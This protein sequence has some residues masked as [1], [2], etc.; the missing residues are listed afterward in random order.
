M[1]FEWGSVDCFSMSDL[2]RPSYTLGIE[3]GATR[4]SVLFVGPDDEVI[5]QFMAGPANLRLMTKDDL[6]A[7]LYAIRQRLPYLPDAIGIGLAGV[8][9]QQDLDT[10]R[11]KV[12]RIWPGVPCAP[13]D[14]LLTAME[15]EPW[16]EECLAQILV[17]SGTGSCFL[18]RHRNGD[19]V[20]VGGRGHILGDRASACD[21]AQNALREVIAQYDS[22]E[23]WSALGAG[24]LTQL[25]LNEPEALID[26]SLVANKTELASVAKTVFDTAKSDRDPISMQVL[27]EAAEMLADDAIATARRLDL[28]RKEPVQFIFNGGVLLKNDEFREKVERQIVA[29]FPNAVLSPLSRPSTWGAVELGRRLLTEE[30]AGE[31]PQDH[32]SPEGDP[33]T[34]PPVWHPAEASP[35]EQRNPKSEKLSELSLSE[36]IGLFVEEDKKIPDAV[37]AA[38]ES[39]EWTIQEVVKAFEGGGRLIYTGA[40]TSGRLGVLDASECPPT[41][42]VSPLQVQG[43]IAGGQS[44]IWSASEGSEDDSAAGARAVRQRNVCEKDVVIAI[45]ASGHAPFIWGCLAEAKERGAKV[46]LLTC[47]PAYT[48]HPLPDQVIALDTGAEILTGS[49]RLK[50]GTA[51]KMTLNLITTLAMTHTGKVESNLMVDLNPSNT[52]L[53]KRATGIVATLAEVSENEAHEALKESGWVVRGALELLEKS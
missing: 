6:E 23:T 19:E 10:L 51:T 48:E 26:W 52:K 43:I 42:R 1:D 40:G 49:T 32:L 17:L 21:I 29:D 46:V 37:L 11:T 27:S 24:I 31:S 35:T 7:H 15:A 16:P 34:I 4:T 9:Q 39:I 2:K 8:R 53:R 12:A 50:A 45:S 20:R 33:Q 41:F 44:A 28:S 36:A 5:E 3:G 18:G 14:D 47:H 30:G 25:Q 13:T 38:S 22:D